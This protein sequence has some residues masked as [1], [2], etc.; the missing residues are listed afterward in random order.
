M[1]ATFVIKASGSGSLQQIQVGPADL[2]ATV[3]AAHSAWGWIGGITGIQS[4]LKFC[5]DSSEQKRLQQLFK[6]IELAP[7]SCLI[8]AQNGLNTIAFGQEDAFGESLSSKLVGLTLCA[9]SH[10]MKVQNAIDV[11]MKCFVKTLFKKGLSGLPGSEETLHGFLVD[12]FQV[13]LN[14][15]AVRHLPEAFDESIS[16]LHIR[17]AR[18]AAEDARLKTPYLKADTHM[19]LGFLKWLTSDSVAPYYTRSAA[20]TRLAACLKTVGYR[21]DDII[22][23]DGCGKRPM[24]HRSLILVTGG[25]QETDHLMHEP[26]G[27]GVLTYM[28]SHFRWETVGAM[29]WNAVKQPSAHVQETFQQDFESIDANISRCL[30]FRWAHVDDELGETQVFPVWTKSASQ[31]SRTAIRL[32]TILFPESVDNIATFYESIA[33]ERYQNAVTSVMKSNRRDFSGKEIQRFQVISV[34]ICFA[35]IAQ[36]AGSS[37]RTLQHSTMIDL[38]SIYHLKWLC[39]E[40]DALLSGGS[41][42]SRAVMAVASIHCAMQFP[43]VSPE[44]TRNLEHELSDESQSSTEVVNWRHTSQIVGWRNGRYAVLPELLFVLEQPLTKSVLG[45]RCVTDFIA[46]IPTRRNGAVRCPMQPG[47]SSGYSDDFIKDAVIEDQ[48]I[49][50]QQI[51]MQDVRPIILGRPR[52]MEPDKLLYISLERPAHTTKEASVALCGRLDGESLGYVSIQDA[53]SAIAL[54]LNDADGQPYPFCQPGEVHKQ[55]S[56]A[57]DVLPAEKVFNMAPSS[58][59]CHSS[60]RLPDCRS[61]SKFQHHVYVQVAGST[62]WAVFLAGMHSYKSRIVFGCPGCAANAGANV[63][64]DTGDGC[65]TLIGYQ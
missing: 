17:T 24:P 58:Y 61:D 16:A 20:V 54:S 27:E 41:A 31:S 22:I 45:L 30:G 55:L 7:A 59:C 1:P 56:D 13:I 2:V 4:L 14:E 47:A 21:L 43:H 35:V 38:S 40:V 65:R 26:S 9:L 11:F 62:P 51:F 39:N 23:W 52:L 44:T 12:N 53:L 3:T 36:L 19:I 25:A 46:N 49:E 34:A 50:R 29:L 28:I 32:A 8:L 37:F 10:N 57:P 5:N 63:C 18:E 15:G 60:G 33:N 6:E 42:F 48:D 64:L